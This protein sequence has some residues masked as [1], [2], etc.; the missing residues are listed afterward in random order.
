[1]PGVCTKNGATAICSMAG[2]GTQLPRT[3]SR[4]SVEPLS[5]DLG[6]HQPTENTNPKP[7]P[8]REWLPTQEHPCSRPPRIWLKSQG[9]VQ[10]GLEPCLWSGP[11]HPSSDSH[12]LANSTVS[13]ASVREY[14][15]AE[16]NHS[17]GGSLC[18]SRT[19]LQT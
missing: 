14:E 6:N 15:R 9:Q 18:P 19:W 17:K 8:L 12:S 10:L 1:M 5:E 2:E 7:A 4:S 13:R 3:I 16:R 11:S